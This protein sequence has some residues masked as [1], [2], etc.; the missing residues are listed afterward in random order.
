MSAIPPLNNWKRYNPGQNVACTVTRSE[1]GGYGVMTCDDNQFGFLPT[2]T[3]L[4]IGQQLEAQFVC[5]H[6]KRLL[7]SARFDSSSPGPDL[8]GSPV[9]KWPVAPTRAGS[10]SIALQESVDEGFFGVALMAQGTE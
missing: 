10:V 9:P 3:V 4:A 5:V 1:P 6:N 2:Q 7:L 8:Q